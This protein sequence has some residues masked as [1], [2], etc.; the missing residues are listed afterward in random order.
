M[1]GTRQELKEYIANESATWAKI[2]KERNIRI[3]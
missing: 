2:I 1:P 3:E